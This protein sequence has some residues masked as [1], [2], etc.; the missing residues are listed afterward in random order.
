MSADN[1]IAI[2]KVRE[3]LYLVQHAVSFYP[4]TMTV[5]EILASFSYAE[6]FATR[7]GASHRAHEL[8]SQEYICEYGVCVFTLEDAGYT[9][10]AS[11]PPDQKEW[12]EQWEDGEF[13]K[14]ASIA[15]TVR[16]QVAPERPNPITLDDRWQA[17]STDAQ[18]A[19]LAMEPSD[20]RAAL[21][22]LLFAQE[23]AELVRQ[24]IG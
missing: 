7:E 13:T 11:L 2:L 1:M 20:Q 18:E 6:A 24:V 10:Y 14:T 19:V 4:E 16:S 5:D 8:Y 22:A 23:N 17:L 21:E 15:H 9:D 3:D 12:R